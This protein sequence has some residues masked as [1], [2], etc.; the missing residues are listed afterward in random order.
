[1]GLLVG[2]VGKLSSFSNS[3]TAELHGAKSAKLGSLCVQNVK[4]SFR[5]PWSS[6]TRSILYLRNFATA[7]WNLIVQLQ[8]FL[9][10]VFLYLSRNAARAR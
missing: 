3:S 5:D 9:S 2:H 1:M 8:L 4:Q 7:E 6:K 10:F